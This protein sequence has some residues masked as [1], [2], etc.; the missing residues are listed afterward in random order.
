MTLGTWTLLLG[1]A[2]N[3]SRGGEAKVPPELGSLIREN[4]TTCHDG[5]DA[6]LDLRT[7]P[8]LADAQAWRDIW[9]AVDVYKMPPP[10]ERGKERM[11]LD[12]RMRLRDA[13]AEMLGPVVDGPHWSKYLEANVWRSIVADVAVPILGAEKTSGLIDVRWKA[14]EALEAL[15]YSLLDNTA[16]RVCTEILTKELETQ[17]PRRQVLLGLPDESVGATIDSTKTLM[18]PLYRALHRS[19][20]PSTEAARTLRAV[21]SARASRLPWAEVWRALCVAYFTSPDVLFASSDEEAP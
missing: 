2:L 1:L 21:R 8:P 15:D 10:D 14:G 13:L 9:D 3:P 12:V 18:E 11:E 17:P 19:P 16:H 6:P 7:L 4:C 5:R 20:M